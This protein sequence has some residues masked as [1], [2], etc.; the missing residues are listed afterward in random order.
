M[1]VFLLYFNREVGKSFL[2]VKTEQALSMV[3]FLNIVIHQCVVER[4]IEYNV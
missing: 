4:K 1:Q 2:A 3:C